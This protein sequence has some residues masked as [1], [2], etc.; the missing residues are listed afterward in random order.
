M[1]RLS[2]KNACG[3]CNMSDQTISPERISKAN[4]LLAWYLEHGKIEGSDT[5]QFN[6]PKDASYIE[7]ATELFAT[8]T[9]TQRDL[10]DA[11][12]DNLDVPK[13]SEALS[14]QHKAFFAK[15]LELIGIDNPDVI[16]QPTEPRP[17][18]DTTDT[19]FVGDPERSIREAIARQRPTVEDILG[20]QPQTGGDADMNGPSEELIAAIREYLGHDA[21]WKWYKKS[22]GNKPKPHDAQL[23]DIAHAVAAALK[24]AYD[25][26]QNHPLDTPL[27][28][29]EL[30]IGKDGEFKAEVLSREPY[31][32]AFFKSLDSATPATQAA[33]IVIPRADDG[34]ENNPRVAQKLIFGANTKEEWAAYHKER[35]WK[36]NKLS[37]HSSADNMDALWLLSSHLKGAEL[38]APF[39]N[40]LEAAVP[41]GQNYQDWV[42]TEQGREHAAALFTKE[43][44]L[45]AKL[46]AEGKPV[47]ANGFV[48]IYKRKADKLVCIDAKGTE[49]ISSNRGITVNL[50]VG[51]KTKDGKVPGDKF[52]PHHALNIAKLAVAK[53]LGRDENGKQ[54]QIVIPIF[55]TGISWG[56]FKKAVKNDIY[57]DKNLNLM[58]V[59]I[60]KESRRNEVMGQMNIQIGNKIV[61]KLD[62]N[63]LLHAG[64]SSGLQHDELK[65]LVA[66]YNERRAPRTLQ[67]TT[68]AAANDTQGSGDTT[69]PQTPARDITT[70]EI[71]VA[72]PATSNDASAAPTAPSRTQ[73]ATRARRASQPAPP[74]M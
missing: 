4:A 59:A 16:N 62:A 37:I 7:K 5:P 70:S 19:A 9:N 61:D 1:S 74:A 55:S 73:E 56:R 20:T 23:D 29:D 2:A 25:T 52:S 64:I 43:S 45:F 51:Q 58:M 11:L 10:L 47:D 53:Q 40:A 33:P 63:K 39:R 44:G 15:A 34:P 35:V 24:N 14:D 48:Q 12:P 31:K 8:N 54:P 65:E 68:E 66:S 28:I 26:A 13:N 72:R 30:A 46:D 60:L 6:L 41:Q 50:R 3:R 49:Y 17:A 27:N 21:V 67:N 22:G 69:T 57:G 71:L 18:T 42:A 38:I 32:T 36:R